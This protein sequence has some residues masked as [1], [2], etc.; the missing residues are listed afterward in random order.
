MLSRPWPPRPGERAHQYGGAARQAVERRQRE[1]D[2]VA[3][4]AA[5]DPGAEWVVLVEGPP[6]MIS[7]RS[8][9]L[10]ALA[11]PGDDAWEPQ[12]ARLLAGRHVGTP[13]RAVIRK[14]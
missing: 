11:V 9:G 2:G 14:L 6:D 5:G 1:V 3:G 12:W 8:R 10:P 7:A 13:L 4:Y